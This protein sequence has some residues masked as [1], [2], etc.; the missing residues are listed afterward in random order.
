MAGA[1]QDYYVKALRWWQ[2]LKAP[3][4]VAIIASI[5]IAAG[6][7]V[8]TQG[9][10]NTGNYT[11]LF[12]GLDQS[13]AAEIVSK[14]K[15]MKIP[16]RLEAGGTA[17]MIPDD[18]VHELRLNLAQE[19]LPKGGGIGFEVFDKPS[20]GQSDFVQQK[21]YHRAL[22]GELERTISSLASVARA[23]I[24][25]VIPER[26]IFKESQEAASA[27]V[28]VKLRAGRVLSESQVQGIV[29]LVSSS[30]PGLSA[31]K[32]TLLDDTGHVLSG[33][34][35][36]V[37]GAIATA[38]D[39]KRKIE[40]SYE[41]NIRS[42]LE[43]AVGVGK[44]AVQVS[45]Q[46]D[47]SQNERTEET[48]DPEK[49]AVRSEQINEETQTAAKAGAP[50][51]VPGT[52]SNLPGGPPTETS[53]GT[54]NNAQKKSQTRNYEINHVVSRTVAAPSKIERIN[55]AILVDGT[56]SG[57]G[58]ARKFAP[59]S[60]EEL[61]NLTAVTKQAFGFVQ[62]RGD[63][64]EIRCVP[65]ATDAQMEGEEAPAPSLVKKYKEY[66]PFAAPLALVVIALIIGTVMVVRGRRAQVLEPMMM[67]GPQY[68]TSV[69]EMEAMM[70][71]KALS[72]GNVDV[73]IA[74]S[75]AMLPKK[76]QDAVMRDTNRAASVVRG[77][78]TED[79]AARSQGQ[80]ANL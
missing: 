9:S 31:D 73:D 59:R 75:P 66:L 39:Y 41:Q 5:V 50:S 35:D 55:V 6:S 11:Y 68:P 56:Y 52:T 44:V 4:K 22:Q 25:L 34:Q 17:I 48:Y 12:T 14:L 23:R 33:T 37:S 49:V 76:V 45:A 43:R 29:H 40:K 60:Q 74:N 51:G 24:H 72:A 58:S 38:F 64:I 36:K 3:L 19:G 27:S 67:G 80:G 42:M 46:A 54:S 63:Q 32:V 57:E 1:F 77:W 2:N 10:V 28:M 69:R 7:V 53:S 62:E 8:L 65:F 20:F 47:L 78:L 70:N 21:N 13:D 61:D 16:Y 30:V 15:E 71:G 79:E 26:R 18:Q